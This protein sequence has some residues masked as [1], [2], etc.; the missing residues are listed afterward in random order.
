MFISCRKDRK[1]LM[2]EPMIKVQNALLVTITFLTIS[3]TASAKAEA[4]TPCHKSGGESLKVMSSDQLK[5]VEGLARSSNIF[6]SRDVREFCKIITQ[7]MSANY[8]E[9]QIRWLLKTYKITRE[10]FFS[11]YID[12]MHCGRRN[13]VFYTFQTYSHDDFEAFLNSGYEINRPMKS[14]DG[15]FMTAFDAAM[16]YLKKSEGKEKTRWRALLAMMKRNGA[17]SCEQLGRTDCIY[18][19]TQ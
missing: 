11:N 19:A 2:E 13:I 1:T 7:T 17:K 16:Q 10:E 3:F 5:T 15:T 12:Y 6:L 8:T 4:G 18:E 9:D 14:Y